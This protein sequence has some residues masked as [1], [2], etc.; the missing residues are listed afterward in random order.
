MID[1]KILRTNPDLVRDSI[2]KRNLKI[3]LDDIIIRDSER[4]TLQQELDQLRTRRNDLSSLMGKW[5][6]DPALLIEAKELK[7]KIQILEST[8]SETE[9]E[10]KLMLASLPNF[11]DPTTAIGPDDSGNIIEKTVGTPRKFDFPIKAHY[12]IGEA[13]GW[14]DIEKGAEVSGAR[15]WYLKWDLVLLQ[16]A[17]MQYVMTEMVKKGFI[18]MIPPYL[19]R[20]GAMYGTGFFPA[21]RSQIYEVNPGE[22]DLF[23]IWTSEVPV[24][25]YHG[26]EIVDV[27]EAIKYVGYS[28]CFRREA[29]T[30]GKDMKGILRGH[31]FD[32]IEMVCFCKPE[33]SQK[34]HDEM[35]A[36]EESIWSSLGIPYH[37]LN[38]CSGD[39]GNPAMKKYDLEAWMPAQDQY[40]EVTSCSNVW[41]FQSRRLGIRYRKEDGSLDYVHT[42]NGTVIAFSRC[43]IAIMENYQNADMTVTIPE[44]LRNYMGGKERI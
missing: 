43:L 24:T 8:F 36:L 12:D 1:I 35:V 42:L 37:K 31:Q 26:G 28:A 22:D 3:N 25:S 44:V 9:E 17:I 23:L 32:K 2:A 27:D 20:E 7:E 41:S 18:P 16:F 6:P 30:Y 14:I 10:Y 38:V 15:F 5:K 13:R 40:R 11:L 39:L 21:D 33:N 4:L 19:V 29:G 34:V